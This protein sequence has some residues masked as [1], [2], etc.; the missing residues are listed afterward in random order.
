MAT[1]ARKKLPVIQ[2]GTLSRTTAHKGGNHLLEIANILLLLLLLLLL[3]IIIQ[4][5]ILT[6][7]RP[8]LA[9]CLKRDGV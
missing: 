8:G 7:E 6:F 1:G 2:E 3:I 4:I 5:I 9:H